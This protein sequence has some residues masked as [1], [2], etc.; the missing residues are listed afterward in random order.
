M[1]NSIP[2]FDPTEMVEDYKINSLCSV[3]FLSLKYH[4]TYPLYVRERLCQL[5][6]RRRENTKI[7]LLLCDTDK[8]S[9]LV[10]QIYLECFKFNTTCIMCWSS[11]EAA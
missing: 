6:N 1:L 11:A 5:Y 2:V 4:S 10:N 8:L 3:I 7:L 9:S